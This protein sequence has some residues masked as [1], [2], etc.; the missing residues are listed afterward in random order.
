MTR[1]AAFPEN[2]G[3]VGVL[4][5]G[6]SAERDISIRTGSGVLAA[7]Q[8]RG[9]DAHGFDPAQRSL[10]ELAAQNF[11]RVFIALHGRFGEDGSIQGA[12]ELLGIP[13]TGSGVMA[14]AL[15]MDK[16]YT[17]RIWQTQQL[18]TP[19]YRVVDATCDLAAVVAELGLPLMVKAPHE[20][21]S[22][23]LVKVEEAP[24]IR[25][26]FTLVA[27]YDDAVLVEQFITGRELTVAILDSG[28]GPRALPIV[29]IVAP[30]G[31]YD[32]EHKYFSNETRYLCP[33][34][35]DPAIAARIQDLAV[36]A[37]VAV[38]C[39][40]WGRVDLMLRFS[41]ADTPAG[42]DAAPEPYLLEINTSPGMTDHSLV[43][44]AAKATGM[45][46]E[47]LALAILRGA[48]LKIKR[49]GT[50]GESGLRPD[51]VAGGGGG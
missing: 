12:L 33:A 20:G 45:S 46:Y 11:K 42:A 5:G 22:L 30:K 16:I 51:A 31:N 23:G 37:F 6:V 47:E 43:P 36:R 41:H 7:L 38:G 40:G 25:D 18:P 13:Y 24:A 15:A 19:K 34:P 44:M 3:K 14:S 9:V 4:M 39:E 28:S 32:Y 2:L 35:L 29:E 10:A 27:E 1:I 48:S 21:S 26:A 17:K 8:S 50:S 49:A